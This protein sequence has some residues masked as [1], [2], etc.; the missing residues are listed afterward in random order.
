[1]KANRN[2]IAI[3]RIKAEAEKRS[4]PISV[5]TKANGYEGRKERREIARAIAKQK[6]NEGE[7]MKR[8]EV[9]WEQGGFR[10]EEDADGEWI[11]YADHVEAMKRIAGEPVAWLVKSKRG[12]IRC[13]WTD[14]PSVTQ[15]AVSEADGDTVT[16]LYAVPAP[17]SPA[18]LTE[19]IVHAKDMVRGHHPNH[20]EYIVAAA[21]LAASPADQDARDAERYRW[22]RSDDIEVLPGQ[23]E[24][25]VIKHA[26][27]FTDEANEVLTESD[28]DAAIDAAMSATPP[29]ADKE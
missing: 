8:F 21:L 11:R 17:A 20:R 28:L 12:M 18:A 22:L 3:P 1:M 23:R 2:R 6:H 15:L 26:L 24:I 10:V 27:P 7:D 14:E 5:A 19:A 29:A 9:Y 13:A 4:M 25:L 16:P